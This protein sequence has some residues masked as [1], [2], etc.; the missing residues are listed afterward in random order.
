MI[1]QGSGGV[2]VGNDI[3]DLTYCDEPRRS[4]VSHLERVCTRREAQLVRQSAFPDRAFSLLWA[5]KEAAYKLVSRRRTLPHFVPRSF[6]VDHLDGEDLAFCRDL[7]VQA[8]GCAAQISLSANNNWAH[9]I[10]TFPGPALTLVR[11]QARRIAGTSECEP[12]ARQQSEAVRLLAKELLGESSEHGTL[13]FSGKIPEF[14]P[15]SANEAA[16]SVSLAHHGK[17]VAAAIAWSSGGRER[18]ASRVTVPVQ[19]GETCST[20]IA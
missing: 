10:A 8:E 19:L 3:V 13:K 9:A 6:V 5:A 14:D 2:L 1:A 20:C 18:P 4:H 7:E 15:S 17:Y 11:W 16:V 12:T